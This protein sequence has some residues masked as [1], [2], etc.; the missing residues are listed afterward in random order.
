MY[1]IHVF[2]PEALPVFDGATEE[3][4]YRRDHPFDGVEL[5]GICNSEEDAES[6][7]NKHKAARYESRNW[8]FHI[9]PIRDELFDDVIRRYFNASR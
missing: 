9:E 1:L 6:L 2:R 8:H 7:I 4:E 5:L 3:Y